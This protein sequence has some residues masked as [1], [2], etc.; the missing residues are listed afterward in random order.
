MKRRRADGSYYEATVYPDG[1][2]YVERKAPIGDGFVTNVPVDSGE[3]KSAAAADRAARDA[4][5][6]DKAARV[7]EAQT[8][9]PL[10]TFTV[11]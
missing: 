4:I 5:T 7:L 3:A 9:Q 6:N 11:S 8:R 1:R 10:L 2:W